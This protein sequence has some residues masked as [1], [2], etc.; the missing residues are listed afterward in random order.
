MGP[1]ACLK[2]AILEAAETMHSEYWVAVN[3]MVGILKR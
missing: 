2:V 1:R 3:R